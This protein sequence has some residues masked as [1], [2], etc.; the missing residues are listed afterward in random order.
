MEKGSIVFFKPT[1][2]E[3]CMKC[4]N[5]IKEDKILH[6]N[7][8]D[9]DSEKSQR[10]LDFISGAIHIQ[11]GIILNPG[12]KIYCSIPKT[13]KY[14]LNYKEAPKT[15]LDRRVDEE[16]EIIPKYKK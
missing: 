6:I 3:D 7:L 1:R 12:E 9:L 11:E 10:V 4:I 16:E 5:Y 15:L 2:F 13:V 14:E 8:G